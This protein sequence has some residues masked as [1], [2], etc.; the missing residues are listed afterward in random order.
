[1]YEGGSNRLAVEAAKETVLATRA[2]LLNVEQNVLLSA[3]QAYLDVRSAT[4]NV[5]LSNNNVRVITEQLR[6]AR[7]RFEVGEVTR[8][9]GSLAEG[10]L[11]ASQSAQVAAQGAL[12]VARENYK[13]AVGHYPEPLT[14]TLRVPGLP[15]TR[16]E[17][18]DIARRSHPT[19]D[20]AQRSLTVADLNLLRARAARKP[21]ITMNAGITATDSDIPSNDGTASRIGIDLS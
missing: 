12:I 21:T 20:A 4:D 3:V 15:K 10:A 2:G 8:T 17:A 18:L 9:D 11:A 1:L 13:L 16:E 7:D 19:I 6:A 14:G 5:R